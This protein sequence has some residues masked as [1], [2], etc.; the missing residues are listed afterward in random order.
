MVISPEGKTICVGDALSCYN[1]TIT[2]T[3][4][5]GLW[6]FIT[7]NESETGTIKG[8]QKIEGNIGSLEN[9]VVPINIPALKAN[10][11]IQ[12]GPYY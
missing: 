1:N 10:E 5:K 7:V 8:T 3:L 2:L 4:E 12:Y 9:F 11:T 6:S